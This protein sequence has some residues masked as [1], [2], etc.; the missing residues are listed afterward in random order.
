VKVLKS[1]CFQLKKGSNKFEYAICL[2]AFCGRWKTRICD[3]IL[4]VPT[5]PYERTS[6]LKF[7]WWICPAQDYI[8]LNNKP[9]TCKLR[10]INRH[11]DGS[12]FP[13]M[14]SCER[15]STHVKILERFTNALK[16]MFR[17]ALLGGQAR[18]IGDG[19]F[20]K[21]LTNR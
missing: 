7:R 15:N 14:N 1:R 4:S 3:V 9:I 8:A 17:E 16:L 13:V 12:T 6:V 2:T 20:A 11:P 10:S 19:R 5:M 21:Q 18:L